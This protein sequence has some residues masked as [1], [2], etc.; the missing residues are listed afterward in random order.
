MKLFREFFKS[1]NL[2]LRISAPATIIIRRLTRLAVAVAA[3]I[4]MKM[5]K[6]Q[7][8]AKLISIVSAHTLNL[9]LIRE[10]NMASKTS[11][12]IVDNMIKPETRN[13]VE[14]VFS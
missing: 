11:R 8:I 9:V 14:L 12:A 6:R 13:D 3:P 1:A 10:E 5:D 7:R 4:N 2:E